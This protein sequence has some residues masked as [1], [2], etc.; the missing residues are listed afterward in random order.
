MSSN[1]LKVNDRNEFYCK[2]WTNYRCVWKLPRHDEYALPIY[3][4][5]VCSVA[6]AIPIT[7]KDIFERENPRWFDLH[8]SVRTCEQLGGFCF[9][10]I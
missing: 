1:S 4:G 10:S 2:K 7:C 6:L 5:I 3:I 8:K 9:L